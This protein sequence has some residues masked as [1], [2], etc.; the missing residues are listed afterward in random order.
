MRRDR[1]QRGR[2][3]EIV[4]KLIDLIEDF[5]PVEDGKDHRWTF[6]LRQRRQWVRLHVTK[7]DKAYYFSGSD[8]DSF[9]YPS[10]NAMDA[11]IEERLPSWIRELAHWK[12]AVAHDPIEAQARLMKKLPIRYR[13]G[14]IQRKNVR[15]LLPQWMPIASA[16]TKN[17]KKEILE[18]L[19]KAIPA[20]VRSMTL[21]RFFDYCR[22]AYQANPKTFRKM[23][24]QSG[25]SGKVYYKKYADGRHGGLLDIKSNSP[26]AFERWYES[27]SWSGCHPWEIYRGGNSTHIDMC[28]ARP[29][30]RQKGW[31]VR[32]QASSSARLVET[33]RI[34]LAL[35]KAD[36][37]V[38]VDEADSYLNR[39]LDQDWVGVV[40]QEEGIAYGWQSFPQEWGVRDCVRLDLFYEENP[41]AKPWLKKHLQ[42]VIYWLPEELTAFLK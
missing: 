37:P 28:V 19:R 21:N 7:Y 34:A 5:W 16:L 8:F 15:L 11:G 2:F 26:R 42:S 41:K 10:K 1:G 29:M 25:L 36:L 35:K 13:T 24:Y 23:G 3:N 31:E 32:L 9:S 33:C 40:P 14:V 17:E 6:F 27:K 4:V 18:I 22:A 30:G 20:P 39:I 12:Q 38:I